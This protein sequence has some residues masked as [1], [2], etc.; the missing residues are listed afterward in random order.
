MG[1]DEGTVPRTVLYGRAGC[2][3][4][5]AAR[6]VVAAVCGRLGEA[7]LERDVDADPALLAAYGDQVPVVTVDGV[8]VG[9]LRIDP[10]RLASRLAATPI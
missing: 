6:T 10:D 4:C 2:H 7:Y 5:E 8:Q 3:L 1:I 9:F